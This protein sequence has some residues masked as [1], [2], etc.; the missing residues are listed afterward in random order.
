MTVSDYRE[1]NHSATFSC[2]QPQNRRGHCD[3]PNVWQ[4]RKS[5]QQL[6]TLHLFIKIIIL[7]HTKT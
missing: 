7:L 2:I 4:I 3:Y 1:L 5:S 6:R